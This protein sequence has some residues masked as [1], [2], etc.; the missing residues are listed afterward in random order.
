MLLLFGLFAFSFFC[1]VFFCL[2]LLLF[3]PLFLFCALSFPRGIARFARNDYFFSF[4][5]LAAFV[6]VFCRFILRICIYVFLR[7]VLLCFC[8]YNIHIFDIMFMDGVYICVIRFLI[9]L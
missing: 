8:V 1:A 9:L 7:I 5:A 4:V 3:L 6:A 2:V